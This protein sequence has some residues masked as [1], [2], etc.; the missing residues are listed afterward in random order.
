MSRADADERIMGAISRFLNLCP[1]A[2][3]GDMLKEMCRGG[4]SAAEAYALLLCASIDADTETERLM[5]R[6]SGRIFFESDAGLYEKES[7]LAKV[8]VPE[9]EDKNAALSIVTIKPFEAF[10]CGEVRAFSDG[11][12]LPQISW[13]AR[14]ARFPALLLDGR[15]YM[16]IVPNEILTIAP[17]AA[18]ARGRVLTLG[19]GMGYFIF[20]ALE[21]PA[22]ETV[23]C[24]E[25]DERVIRLFCS[26]IRPHLPRPEALTILQG[27][28]FLLA[29]RLYAEENFDFVFADLWHDAQDGP[30]MYLR[31]KQ[32]ELEAPGRIYSY[33]IENTL[34]YY[35]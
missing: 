12:V 5:L 19:L 24:V 4:L 16:S 26:H 34:K 30:E 21:N 27:D 6:D 18:R 23:T 13:F 32:M 35:I 7:Y 10:P 20:K 2:I 22:V 33:W 29:P 25:R 15:L 8:P 1:D 9:T 31:L 3:T 17:E 14:E 28:A 11:A